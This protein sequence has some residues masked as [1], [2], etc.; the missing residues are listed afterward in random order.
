MSRAVVDTTA[1]NTGK[2][3]RRQ[4]TYLQ[5]LLHFSVAERCG[6]VTRGVALAFAVALA[7]LDVEGSGLA[8]RGV[9]WRGEP[10][11]GCP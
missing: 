6:V 8:W 4:E 7:R 3:L 5:F 1:S 11:K 10:E 9:E 2:Q